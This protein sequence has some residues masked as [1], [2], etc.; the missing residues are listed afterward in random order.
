MSL[1]DYA[2]IFTQQ[3]GLCKICKT[4]TK[5]RQLA[6]DHCHKT[7]KIRGLLCAKCNVAIGM[8]EDNI[9]FLTEAISYLKENA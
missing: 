9:E 7:G 5:Q 1:E 4:N 2:Q 8:F 3:N 6:V